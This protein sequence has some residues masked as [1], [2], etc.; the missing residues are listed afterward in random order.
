MEEKGAVYYEFIEGLQLH[1]S[2]AHL[3]DNLKNNNFE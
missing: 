2:K 3:E 1:M